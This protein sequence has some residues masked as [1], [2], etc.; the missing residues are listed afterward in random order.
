MNILLVL[1]LSMFQSVVWANDDRIEQGGNF[2]Y[3][4]SSIGPD[5]IFERGIWRS[6]GRTDNLQ[7]VALNVNC[8]STHSP[9]D[10]EGSALIVGTE[11]RLLAQEETIVMS[12]ANPGM[13]FYVYAISSN[14]D[15]RLL[16]RSLGFIYRDRADMRALAGVHQ[17]RQTRVTLAVLPGAFVFRAR[18]YRNGELVDTWTNPGFTGSP[19]RERSEQYYVP[20]DQAYDPAL[21]FA[22]ADVSGF[23]LPACLALTLC[24]QGANTSGYRAEATHR[25][26]PRDTCSSLKVEHTS[27]QHY[28]TRLLLP[29]WFGA[30]L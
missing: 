15:W 26:T 8:L 23:I 9:G 3:W 18:H 29:V 4:A 12:H 11:S 27:A 10:P 5:Q 24:H 19:T 25:A 14:V 17:Q 20:D 16:G 30:D 13:S 7:Q 28:F 22:Y 1:V 21:D 2:V 6:L